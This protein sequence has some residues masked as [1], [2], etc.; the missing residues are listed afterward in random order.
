MRW[1]RHISVATALSVAQ[2]LWADP[3]DDGIETA[4][5]QVE[6][7]ARASSRIIVPVPLAGPQLGFGVA[8]GAVWFYAPA[9]NSR[10]WTT[11][12]AVLTTTNGSYGV[13]GKHSMTLGGDDY[14]LDFTVGYAHLNTVYYGVGSEAGH[15]NVPVPIT[16]TPILFQGQATRRVIPRLYVGGRVRV[17]DMSTVVRDTAALAPVDG[18]AVTDRRRVVALGPVVSLDMTD[19]SLNPRAGSTVNG[20]WL[21]AVPAL[22][23]DNAYNKANLTV[24]H[25]VDVNAKTVVAFRGS[26]CS[27]SADAP[28][29][30]LCQYGSS[31]NLRG[32][33]NG[34]YR[35]HA[36]WTLQ[37]E[38]RRQLAGR[39]GV[40]AF[41]GIGGIARGL[42]A[43]GSSTILPGAGG[44]VRYEVSREYRVN[45]RLDAATGK[46][47]RAIN[48]SL[49]EAF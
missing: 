14:R 26:L 35:D 37:T 36:S 12:V 28:F 25:Y 46:D 32:Y 8:L 6:L 27:A 33:A 47:S 22:G 21:F 45:I 40:V 17:L 24:N 23:S 13:G 43:I 18:S 39:F 11:G 20:Q 44:G 19:G 2:P 10:P 38:W 4:A 49:G 30:E 42:G 9:A 31:S 3:P 34:Q 7:A 1:A 48:L 5:D 15:D 41:A 16:Q 29:F